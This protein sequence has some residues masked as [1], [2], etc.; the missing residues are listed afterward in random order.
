[1]NTIRLSL[2]GPLADEY[3]ECKEG[4]MET[5]GDLK[6]KVTRVE[7]RFEPDWRERDLEVS[8]TNKPE[9]SKKTIHR[10]DIEGEI[11]TSSEKKMSKDEGV[12]EE[13]DIKDASNKDESVY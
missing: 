8:K 7:G 3:A 13:L 4:D 2:E 10:R 1:M 11:Q 12:D 5:L 6:F 9:P